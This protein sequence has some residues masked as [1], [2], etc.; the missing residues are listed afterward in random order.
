MTEL[1]PS[2]NEFVARF[3]Y[4]PWYTHCKLALAQ[5]WRSLIGS[6]FSGFGL[7]WML[8]GATTYFLGLDFTGLHAFGVLMIVSTGLALVNSAVRYARSVPPG[9]EAETHAIQQVAHWRRPRWEYRLAL[10]LLEDRLATTD[11]RLR[12]LYE[13]RRYVGLTAAPTLRDY[14]SWVEIRLANLLKMAD[15]ATRLLV[16]EL[17]RS[18]SPDDGSE[19]SP[20]TIKEVIDAIS[21][22]YM[23]TLDFEVQSRRIRPPEGF[24][25]I[26]LIQMGWSK[27]IRDA[28]EQVR[29]FL[30]Q[31]INLNVQSGE[32][33]EFT[34]HVGE[35]EGINEFLT[36][37]EKLEA[38]LVDD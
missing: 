23:E 12:D 29:R 37:L 22:L 35:P 33:I 38:Q 20:V 28:I 15:V 16:F 21:D 18:L 13:G 19:P 25:Q 10:L 1:Q 8:V 5:E 14:V 4:V 11:R 31:V 7:L 6:F 36:E 26:H 34:I 30:Q 32:R 9:F 27:P 17:P 24:E 2:Q 3:T